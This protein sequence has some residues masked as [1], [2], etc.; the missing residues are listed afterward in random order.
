MVF[1]LC[2]FAIVPEVRR[3]LFS[4]VGVT[5]KMGY[6]MEEYVPESSLWYNLIL[7]Q[8]M[9][10]DELF[11]KAS[12]VQNMY[13]LSEI[14]DQAIQ[15]GVR[16]NF[17][18]SFY[19]EFGEEIYNFMDLVVNKIGELDSNFEIASEIV[20]KLL[21]RGAM[22]YSVDA[23]DL[24]DT[25]EW[26]FEGH[27][28]NIVKAY[29]DYINRTTKFMEIAKSATNGR[30]KNAKMD[31]SSF[32]LE[33]SEDSTIDVAKITD[34]E[35]DLGFTQEVGCGRNIIKI[36]E[37]EVEIIT[38]GGIRNYTDLADGSD[39]VL[40][41]DTSFGELEVRLYPDKENENL[42][43]VEVNDKDLLDKIEN[44]NEKIGK[45]CLLGGLSVNEAINLGSF[46]R[47]RALIHS[48]K[49][50]QSDETKVDLW[51][52]PAKMIVVS[53]LQETQ[54]TLHNKGTHTIL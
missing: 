34:G 21:S 47:S 6:R 53:N 38:Q 37:S 46:N 20:C 23:E 26:E 33:Y 18:R 5:Y 43:T 10:L 15:S 22:L 45:N 29:E 2:E 1:N 3:L 49:I 11:K 35:R 13:Q 17:P 50:G 39:I 8:N 51:K 41:F 40:T 4:E 28:T 12:K 16:F 30:I 54:A 52:E 19:D 7:N 25:L 9:E 31:N 44:Y 14:V 27:K 36:G 24:F 48:E 32:Y 42:I